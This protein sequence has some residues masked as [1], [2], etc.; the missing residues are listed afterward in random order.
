MFCGGSDSYAQVSFTLATILERSRAVAGRV[1]D[2]SELWQPLRSRGKKTAT[3]QER[4]A[5]S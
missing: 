5:M 2:R 4:R 3:K 1:A